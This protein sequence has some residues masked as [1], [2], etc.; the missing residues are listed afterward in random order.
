MTATDH[1]DDLAARRRV[2][3]GVADRHV[4]A[5]QRNQRQDRDGGQILEQ[6][7]RERQAAVRTAELLALGKSLQADRGRRQAPAR[8]RRSARGFH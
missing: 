7:D 6:Q 8:G 1:A 3:A 5:E 2:L 4:R